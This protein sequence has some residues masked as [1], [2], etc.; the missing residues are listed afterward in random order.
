MVSPIFLQ[1]ADWTAGHAGPGGLPL[2]LGRASLALL[3]GGFAFLVLRAVLQR[4]RYRAAGV[5]SE[6]DLTALRE[7][8]AAVERRTVGE[9][10][11][12]VLERSD[13]HPGALWLAAFL[14]SLVGT[15]ALV[16]WLPWNHPELLLVT[17]IGLGALGYA[18][19]WLLPGFQ[20]VFVRESRASEVAEEQAFQEFHR[21]DLTR[22]EARTGVLLFVSLFERRVLVL[23]DEG[24]HARVAPDVW[25]QA[26]DAVLAGIR[27][28]S[29]RD[30]LQEGIRRTGEILA[31]EFP[32]A[33][34]DR[35]EIP[36]RVIVRPR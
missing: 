34:G 7:A 10:L 21:H 20:R 12:V 36:D 35:N 13:P 23:A 9:V 27:R 4:K 1:A 19:A 14:S 29:L 31:R 17:Q 30:G 16:P 15:A 2:W 28:G 25:K 26:N 22:T 3:V 24:I 5:L 6:A 18:C 11:P 8:V 32:V 33:E